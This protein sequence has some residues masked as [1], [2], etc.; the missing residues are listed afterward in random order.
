[1]VAMF[2]GAVAMLPVGSVGGGVLAV[3]V[4][5]GMTEVGLAPSWFRVILIFAVGVIAFV[6]FL[7][8]QQGR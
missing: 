7:Q 8:V 4:G 3:V 2:V 1:M 6:A 5:Y